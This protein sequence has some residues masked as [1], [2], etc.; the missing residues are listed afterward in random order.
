[1]EK[2]FSSC[3]R[4][5]VAN[6]RPVPRGRGI[7]RA[8]SARLKSRLLKS[9]LPPSFT[10]EKGF[11]LIELVI[12]VSMIGI[13]AAIAFPNFLTFLAKG[14][15]TEA[16]VLLGAIASAEMQ[17]K[18]RT[19]VFVSCPVNPPTAKGRWNAKSAEWNRIGFGVTGEVAYQYEVVA[20]ETGF[21]AYARANLDSDPVIDVWEIS[22]QNLTLVN[23]TNDVTE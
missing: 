3:E 22:S 6:G 8:T 23:A 19:V 2:S 4:P 9:P 1:M 20:D 21:V 14:R 18:L 13:L 5:A 12:V 7:I 17:N 11:T 16:K 15:Q 10:K